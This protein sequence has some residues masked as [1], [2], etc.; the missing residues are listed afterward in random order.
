MTMHFSEARW[1]TAWTET[2]IAVRRYKS[3]LPAGHLRGGQSKWDKRA[4]QVFNA[5]YCIE[6]AH[7]DRVV[8]E[9]LDQLHYEM[10]R[11]EHR[12]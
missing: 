9:T 7:P 4:S 3:Y 10:F 12:A 2:F 6:G 5:G 1:R 8:E 11:N